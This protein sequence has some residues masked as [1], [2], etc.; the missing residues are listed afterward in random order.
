MKIKIIKTF[1]IVLISVLLLA[2]GGVIALTLYAD[3]I[4]YNPTNSEFKVDNAQ[5]ALDELYE[6][7]GNGSFIDTTYLGTVNQTNNTV[8]CWLIPGYKNLTAD[9]F[10]VEYIS[11]N[12][13]MYIYMNPSG[14]VGYCSAG[15]SKTY[16]ANN[17]VLTIGGLNGTHSD[18]HGGDFGSGGTLYVTA[19][20]HLIKSKKLLG[21]VAYNSNT[22]NCSSSAGYENLTADN[23]VVEYASA[24]SSMY[25]YMNPSGTVGYGSAS[26]S[27]SYNPTTGVLTVGGLN[28]T[29]T[30]ARGDGGSGGTL[31]ITGK[32]YLVK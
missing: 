25:I 28:G 16:D 5:D 10:I 9:D 24:N 18:A 13:S 21:N 1:L 22:I 20:V 6:L 15:M 4:I 11:A 30:D 14:A 3:D 31:R 12:S 8:N 32:V 19:K 27:K 17:G 2:S 26:M 7:V 29:H 23:F